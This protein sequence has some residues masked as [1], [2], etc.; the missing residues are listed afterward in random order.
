MIVVVGSL[1]LDLVVQVE[2]MPLPG[3]TLIATAYAE[4]PGGK[5][6]NQAVAA[7]RTGGRVA[8][9]GRIGDDEAGMRLRAG[10]TA[11]GIDVSEVRVVGG[12][13]GRALIEV[14]EAGENRI[15]VVPGAN[16]RLAAHQLPIELL[17]SADFVLLQREVPDEVVAATVRLVGQAGGRS[18]LNLAPAG[19][20]A[21]DVLARVSLLLVNESEAALLLG[22][23]D[24]APVTA[25]PEEAARRL[26][27]QV[28][29]DA[30]ITLGAHGVVH[31]GRSGEGRIEG[32]RV[33]VVDTTAAGDAFAGALATALDGG[34]RLPDAL[35]FACAAGA[36]AVTRPGAQPS[37]PHRDEVEALAERSP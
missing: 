6:A 1:N 5:G 12:P 9:I 25:A 22:E 36:C 35:R 32:F 23:D 17:A 33:P 21:S 3:E 4:H 27:G 29:G 14:D 26:S 19:V 34:S 7:A 16:A 10:L 37:L 20:L 24:P 18:I 8:M 31:A 15:V 2:R 11:E 30:V 28:A 13:T